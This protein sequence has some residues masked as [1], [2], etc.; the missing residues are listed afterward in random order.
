[1]ENSTGQSTGEFPPRTV[2]DIPVTEHRFALTFKL[3][4]ACCSVR[5]KYTVTSSHVLYLVSST[6]TYIS[7][8]S[9]RVLMISHPAHQFAICFIPL[10]GHHV[11]W[12]SLLSVHTPLV[13]WL[14][15]PFFI[16]N[17]ETRQNIT[18]L[19]F[20]STSSMVS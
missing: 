18:H 1:M 11:Q 15:H 5:Y 12:C 3:V 17:S 6:P 10:H 8:F 2:N 20:S 13:I 4:R 7:L 9:P 19:N 14:C 16:N